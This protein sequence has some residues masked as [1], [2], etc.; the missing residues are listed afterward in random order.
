[1]IKYAWDLSSSPSGAAMETVRISYLFLILSILN[2][3]S[4]TALLRPF[5]TTNIVQKNAESNTAYDISADQ[6]MLFIYFNF[7]ICIAV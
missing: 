4:F 6:L 3:L 2:I 1:M 5:V 7:F